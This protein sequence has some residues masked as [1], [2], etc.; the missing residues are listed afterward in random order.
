MKTGRKLEAEGLGDAKKFEEAARNYTPYP[1]METK[2]PD[3]IFKAE[4]FIFPTTYQLDPDMTVVISSH[5]VDELE[6]IVDE[7]VFMKN[8]RILLAGSAEELREQRGKSI[9]D[10]YRE[11]YGGNWEAV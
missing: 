1:Y 3:V 6:K 5:L 4:G 7:A 10:L 2:N 11:I 9:T 8:G